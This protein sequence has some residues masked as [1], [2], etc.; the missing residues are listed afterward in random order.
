MLPNLLGSSRGGIYDTVRPDPFP[1]SAV[2]RV[3]ADDS[4]MHVCAKVGS[5]RY[6]FKPSERAVFSCFKHIDNTIK[7]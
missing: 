1:N 7:I 4:Q 2:K 5:R 3:C 6:M